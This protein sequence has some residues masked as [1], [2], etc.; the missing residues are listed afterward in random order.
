MYGSEVEGDLAFRGVDLRDFFRPGGGPSGLSLRRLWVLIGA[1]PYEAA[2]RSAVRREAGDAK[3][4]HLK[5][6]R[7]YYARK[8]AEQEGRND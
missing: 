8:R 5:D 6:R 4:S 3:A 1:M 7:H 2:W